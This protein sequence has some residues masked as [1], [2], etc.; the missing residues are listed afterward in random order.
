M[1]FDTNYS[2]TG[3]LSAVKESPY[4]LGLSGALMH[5]YENE[6]NYNAIMKSVGLSELKYY[7]ETG[8]D[9]F[10]NEASAFSGFIDK[11]IAFFKA[12]IEKIKAIF[13]KFVAVIDQYHLSDKDFVKKYGDKLV[14][15]NLADFEFEGYK[16]GDFSDI[17][18][19]INTAGSTLELSLTRWNDYYDTDKDYFGKKSYSYDLY[20]DPDSIN[21]KKE[22]QRA[23]M[24]G[25][26]GKMDES[27]FKD[28]LKKML[29]GDDEKETLD[30]IN[31]REQLNIITDTKENIKNVEKSQK[32]IEKNINTLIKNLDKLPMEIT[33]SDKY[34]RKNKD[35]DDNKDKT[36]NTVIKNINNKVDLSK[37]R[38][39]DITIAF[40]MLVKAY[41]DRNRQAKAICVK[42]LSYKHESALVSESYYSNSDDIFAGVSII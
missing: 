7:Q 23:E 10:L 6:C 27:E 17:H 42:A 8:K 16:F 34:N 25:K 20:K 19:K 21:D 4:E 30:K 14:R 9:L 22:K 36:I 15:K 29:Y 41:K 33:K 5:V 37:S 13:K 28:E 3:D 31:I 39:N 11:V 26:S 35:M 18:D 40:G 32:E 38:S 12:V 2:S 24:L 1:I